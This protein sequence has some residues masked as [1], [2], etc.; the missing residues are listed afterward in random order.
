MSYSYGWCACAGSH[1]FERPELLRQAMVEGLAQAGV[2]CWLPRLLAYSRMDTFFADLDV[3]FPPATTLRLLAH[4]VQV[5][6]TPQVSTARVQV[7]R[8]CYSKRHLT[9]SGLASSHHPSFSLSELEPSVEWS[10][11]GKVTGPCSQTVGVASTRYD[12]CSGML[13]CAGRV[14]VAVGPEG[15]WTDNELEAFT[16]SSTPFCEV[17]LG[18]RILKTETAVGTIPQYLPT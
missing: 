9:D 8:S 6:H 12:T 11:G 2:D 10:L 18:E 16:T 13:P 14:V 7:S 4:P 1:F 3:L 15:G 5:Q 17:N